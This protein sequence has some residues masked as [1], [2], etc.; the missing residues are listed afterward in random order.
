MS[1]AEHPR[2]GRVVPDPEQFPILLLGDFSGRVN[3]R[4]RD[5]LAGRRPVP[6]DRD[7]LDDV[8][9]SCAVGLDLPGARLR[10]RE[11]EDFHPDRILTALPRGEPD[12]E[13]APEPPRRAASAAYSGSLLDDM[14]THEEEARRP[15]AA[16]DSL[17]L[18]AFL[19]RVTAPHLVPR[20]DPEAAAREARAAASAAGR[21]RAILHHPDF[22]AVEASWRAVDWLVR[23]L[24]TDGDLRLYLLDASLGE[25]LADPRALAATLADSGPWALIAA[26][27][28]FG[29]APAD[30]R[31]LEM[32]ARIAAAVEAPFLAE[33]LPP[34]G[35]DSPEEWGR[36]RRSPEARWIGLALP[37]FLLRLPYGAGTV[38]VESLAFEE[39]PEPDHAQYLWGS[40]AFACAG[41]LGESFL[42]EGWALRP[43]IRRRL[44]GLPVHFYREGGETVAKPCAEVVLNEKDVDFLMDGGFMPLA[45]VKNEDAAV[46]VRF[47]SVADPPAA[48]PGRWAR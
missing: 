11:L 23:R 47:H 41:L 29:Q 6:V 40:P 17:D 46:L 7:N 44:D 22:Q 36:F 12:A 1:F 30:A 20:S 45:S 27:Y 3:R 21:L 37:R 5:G 15:P 34:S 38:P 10:F 42:A 9:A 13:P 25:V 19:K 33:A 14:V 35:P 32:L 4:V 31:V 43:G 16:E 18:P 48:L 2:A 26:N 28:V 24:D 8:I 39:M